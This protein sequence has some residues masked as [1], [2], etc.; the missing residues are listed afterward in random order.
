MPAI[1]IGTPIFLVAQAL[2]SSYVYSEAKEYGSRSPAV[3]GV[4]VFTVGAA[5][6]VAF[7]TAVGLIMAELI[8][9]FIYKVG[10]RVGKQGPTDG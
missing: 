10:V 1:G 3:V 7:N 2:I 6:A 8:I 9:I 4:S 5:F